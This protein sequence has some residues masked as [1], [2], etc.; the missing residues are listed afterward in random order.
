M[1][2]K[3]CRG[4]MWVMWNKL[5]QWCRSEEEASVKANIGI[6][7]PGRRCKVCFEPPKSIVNVSCPWIS[8]SGNSLSVPALRC[9]SQEESCRPCHCPAST[10]GNTWEVPGWAADSES[11]WKSGV[12][13]GC[14]LGQSQDR[15]G[16]NAA[17]FAVFGR[18]RH[19]EHV[20]HGRSSRST[21]GWQPEAQTV[22]NWAGFAG[23]CESLSV[24]EPGFV[25]WLKGGSK[26][27]SRDLPNPAKAFSRQLL[28]SCP[29][30]SSQTRG[31]SNCF[32]G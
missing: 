1:Q 6:A 24:P 17:P 9:S 11:T 5:T 18:V 10:W 30:P 31:A 15:A 3:G 27:R 32:G 23:L 28:L 2:F 25:L 22:E 14:V 29:L 21:P 13:P 26:A 19:P 12:S 16:W 20:Q 4:K 8:D 7:S